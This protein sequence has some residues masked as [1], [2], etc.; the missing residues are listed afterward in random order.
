MKLIQSIKE[1]LREE[2]EP[3][4][5]TSNE[6]NYQDGFCNYFADNL[7]VKL[8]KQYPDRNIRYYLILADLIYDYD[9]GEL[10]DSTIVHAYVKIDNLYLDSNG[11]STEEDVNQRMQDWYDEKLLD[12]PED[13]RLE[14][15]HKEYNKIPKRFLKRA[16]ICDSK[17]IKKD[18]DL[19]LSHP[20]VKQLLESNIKGGVNNLPEKPNK[21]LF[22]DFWLSQ[23]ETDGDYVK[24]Y[25]FGSPDLE[26]LDP[27]HFGKHSYTSSEQWWGKKRLFFYTNLNQKERIVSGT[28]YTATVDLKDLYPF[29]KDP[30]NLYDIAAKMYG[31]QNIPYQMQVIYMSGMLEKM[32][33]K[34]M[35]YKWHD[36]SLLAV[37]WEKVKNIT[38][39][40]EKKEYKLP[41]SDLNGWPI[42]G[43]VS[44]NPRL[45]DE[46]KI[47]EVVRTM[48]KSNYPQDFIDNYLNLMKS[49]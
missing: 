32:G 3:K 1:I 42:E 20:E 39:K 37:I 24:L 7:I 17:R 30:L 40:Q 2:L 38:S 34:G 43:G 4:W 6:Y 25:H 28:L 33:Y 44:S 23:L 12:L 11:L 16:T 46:D 36:D 15:W 45:S 19:F 5:N 27:S 26:Y 13:Y 47:N 9:E 8:K 48:K 31:S 21:V 18:I 22:N 35:I 14:I 49:R 10:E 29:N 41:T